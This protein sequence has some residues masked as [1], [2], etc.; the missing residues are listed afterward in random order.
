MAILFDDA[1]S[2]YLQVVS[3]PVA[4]PPFTM[5]CWVRL[6]DSTTHA[7]MFIG[8]P[9]PGGEDDWFCVTSNGAGVSA[10]QHVSSV[11]PFEGEATI[12]NGVTLNNW[13]HICGIF[14][15]NSSRTIFLDGGDKTT[16]A[17][18]MAAVV[19]ADSVAIGR[20]GDNTPDGYTSGCIGQVGI[21]NMALADA[22]VVS[23]A[24]GTT[25]AD[26]QAGNLVAHWPLADITDLTD[27]VA[28]RTLTAFNTPTTCGTSPPLP[29]SG[30]GWWHRRF[31]Q[32]R[33]VA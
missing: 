23:L 4:V 29:G 13:H 1:Q 21:W 28:A 14:T 19:A 15:N 7:C 20:M 22:D 9:A 33:G 6:D 11:P 24:G 16:D 12:V 8:N 2:E 25:P 10:M 3:T 26:I 32:S 27:T 30:S 17:T 18:A 31:I 5:A